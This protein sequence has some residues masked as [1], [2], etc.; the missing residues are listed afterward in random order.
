MNPVLWMAG[1][2]FITAASPCGVVASS[3]S[4]LNTA[5]QPSGS[6]R[7]DYFHSSKSLDDET[8]LIGA[9]LQV[10]LLP[11]FRPNLDGKVEARFTS[12]DLD[13]GKTR[14][15]LLEAFVSARF[16]KADLRLGKQ[17]VAWGRADGINPTDNLTPRDYTVMLPFEDDQR[18]G[19][20][21]AKLDVFLTENHTLTI[22]TTP[23]FEPGKIPL[24]L[25]QR[26]V[27][28]A[29]TPRK[30]S[31]TEVG[32]RLNRVGEGFDW[33]VSYFHGYNLLPDF[34][35]LGPSRLGLHHDRIDV[36]GA[37]FARNFGRF[38]LR[39]EAAYTF[40]RD[41]R[42]TDLFTKNAQ[43]FWI[44]GVDRTF[45]ANLNVNVQFFQRRVRSHRDPKAIL[46]SEVRSVAILN[47]LLDGQLDHT[48]N[49]VSFRVSNKWLHDTLEAEIFGIANLNHGDAFARP[50][51]TYSLS[52]RW[53]ATLGAELYRGDALTQFGSQRANRGLF[54]ETRCSF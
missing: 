8:D 52:D 39:G 13:D 5:L 16:A 44:F 43:L 12:P 10:K 7:A 23:W 29:T 24:A 47:A 46:D 54:A 35:L 2:A 9:T 38:G 53:K 49:A 1:A 15:T 40:S 45:F 17:I 37:D 25:A 22:F 41:Q 3:W 51:M 20:P 6:I 19:T 11:T 42:G 50:S 27:P 33:S 31:N 28:H 26:D 4:E 36:V 14:A 21:A 34:R 48:S 18:V 32:L 30:L